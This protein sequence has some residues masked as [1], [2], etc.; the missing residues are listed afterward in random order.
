[1]T[2]E[3]AAATGT[4]SVLGVALEG[5]KRGVKQN[6]RKY[7]SFIGMYLHVTSLQVSRNISFLVKVYTR[8]IG[9]ISKITFSLSVKTRMLLPVLEISGGFLKRTRRGHPFPVLLRPV[10]YSH[11]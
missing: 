8:L 9:K 11:L 10:P 6:E 2:D 5:R 3:R 1:M 4:S 7:M